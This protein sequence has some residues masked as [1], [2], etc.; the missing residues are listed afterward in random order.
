M[1]VPES[2]IA[3]AIDLA[4]AARAMLHA[5]AEGARASEVKPDRT[6]VTATDRA[7]EQR[8]RE[9][10]AKRFPAHGIWGEEFGREQPDAEWQWV[11]DPIDG[12]AQFIAGIPVYA[13]LIALAQGG[14]PVLGI[15]DFPAIGSR[16]IGC[17]GRPTLLNGEVCQ[18]SQARKIAHAMMSTSSPDFYSDAERPVLE[19]L[20]KATR[21]RIYGG[22]ALSYA[23]LASGSIDLSCDT[24]FQVYDFAC[25]RPII[26]GAGGVVT[27]WD[28]RQLTLASGNRVL[29]AA[30]PELH[31]LALQQIRSC[32]L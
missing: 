15:M 3:T 5:A 17:K 14:I 28:G 24:G 31:E 12:T 32:H 9:M 30:T 2:C 23:R 22:A 26:E 13:T 4:D 6:F 18:T 1:A 21:W 8:L 11:L 10:I 29:A 20:R 16:W 27:D 7:I 19:S 25:F